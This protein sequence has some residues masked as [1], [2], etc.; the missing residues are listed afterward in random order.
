MLTKADVLQEA[1]QRLRAARAQLEEEV[2]ELDRRLREVEGKLASNPAKQRALAL[3][4][5][6]ACLAP[7]GFN[8]VVAWGSATAEWDAVMAGLLQ[9]TDAL[10]FW[11][12]QC[13]CPSASSCS[14]VPLQALRLTPAKVQSG[15]QW[16]GSP[17]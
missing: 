8:M 11:V 13:P 12:Q 9:E 4:V 7:P 2:G 1:S 6:T 5:G 14:S 10:L 3:Q 17:E 15:S 16:G